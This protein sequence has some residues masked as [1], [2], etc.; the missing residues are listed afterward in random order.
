MGAA[1]GIAVDEFMERQM[2]M[3]DT[4]KSIFAGAAAEPPSPP[5]L[6]SPSEA[7]QSLGRLSLA[8]PGWITMQEARRPFSPMDD[9][10]AFGETDEQGRD[11]VAR[12]GKQHDVRFDIVPTEGRIYFSRGAR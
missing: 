7:S 12:F 1:P 10:Y 6:D 9:Q 11:N 3:F 8:G 5:K 2:P 4:L